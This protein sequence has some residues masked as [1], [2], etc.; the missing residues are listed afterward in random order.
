LRILDTDNQGSFT[1]FIQD[2]EIGS[3]FS[4]ESQEEELVLLDGFYNR[5]FLLSVTNVRVSLVVEEDFQDFSSVKVVSTN[6]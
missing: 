2:V 4:E 3:V 6:R 1:F 5:V